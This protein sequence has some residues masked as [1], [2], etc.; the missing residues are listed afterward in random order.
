MKTLTGILAL[1]LFALLPLYAADLSDLTY[2]TTDGE[3]T[4][5]DCR[6]AARGELI[7]P[8]TIAGN[9]VTSIGRQAFSKCTGLTSI[10][11]PDGVTSLGRC[12]FWGCTSLTNITIPDRDVYDIVSGT[13][14][15]TSIGRRAF[16]YC[17]SLT[18]ITIPDSVTWIGNEAFLDCK[19]LTAVTFLGDA[20]KVG[21]GVFAG[22]PPT[23][24]RKA[25]AKGWGDNIGGRP[26][27]MISEKP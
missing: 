25:E 9:P 11:I 7:I 10:T 1:F 8:D 21:K 27:K 3:F 5:T 2:T 6:V 13:R 12:A 17:T 16:Y 26:V 23:I 14:G 15:V 18:S 19:S 20:P 24:Y 22:A 4:I